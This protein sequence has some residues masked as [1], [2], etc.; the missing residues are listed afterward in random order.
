MI[1]HMYAYMKWFIHTFPR[2]KVQSYTL[3]LVLLCTL[4]FIESSLS[5][6]Q[7]RSPSFSSAVFSALLDININLM[8]TYYI[9]YDTYLS[10]SWDW[11]LFS[12]SAIFASS[13][14]SKF[15][16]QCIKASYVSSI[17]SEA[18]LMSTLSSS[19]SFETSSSL[20]QA[21][22]GLDAVLDTGLSPGTSDIL[23]IILKVKSYT[24]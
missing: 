19:T 3:S 22:W 9:L 4:S 12:S 1:E 23:Y 10:K 11:S 24:N 21:F 16:L 14:R 15:S 5:I 2:L 18:V 17:F 6:V 20:A 8:I 7:C 13:S